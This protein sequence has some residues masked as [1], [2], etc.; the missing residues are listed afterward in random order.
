VPPGPLVA[1]SSPVSIIPT[2][3]GMG[4]RRWCWALMVFIGLAAC[5]TSPT[6]TSP[7]TTPT[8]VVIAP[9]LSPVPASATPPPPPTATP[10]PLAAVVNGEAITLTTYE[11]EVARCRAGLTSVGANPDECPARVW[12]SLLEQAVVEQA[13]I[14]NGVTVGEGELDSALADL[15][16]QQGGPEAHTAWLAANLYT[17]DEF[18]EALRHEL[19]RAQ[20]AAPILAG[21]PSTA[22]QVR[23]Q[24]ILVADETTAQDL[25]AQL[26]AGADFASLAVQFSLDLS[27]RAAGG[28]LGWFPRGMLTAPEL[29]E[30]AFALNV[31]ETSGVIQTALGYGIVQTL[32]RDPAR[33]LSPDAEQMLKTRAYQTWI[34]RLVAEAD[35][36][37]FINP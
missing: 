4:I 12:Q 36:Q 27:S 17:A 32:E 10:E 15:T 26:Q 34:E 29:E 23:A 13:A 25:L 21:V 19:L 14:A 7:P 24:M 5:R 6:P 33:A 16:A 3:N 20:A 37:T 31:G 11:R 22:E 1:P 2:L 18:R 8:A 9:T 35:V 28:D 30:A